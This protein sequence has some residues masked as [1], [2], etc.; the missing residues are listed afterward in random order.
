LGALVASVTLLAGSAIV[1]VETV[2]AL[3]TSGATRALGAVLA[4]STRRTALAR[5]TIRAIVTLDTDGTLAALGTLETL[6]TL[7]TLGTLGSNASGGTS[8]ARGSVETI[9]TS[10]AW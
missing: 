1:S 3:V 9:L 8:S 2:C 10:G 5:H 7:G 4:G 6:Q